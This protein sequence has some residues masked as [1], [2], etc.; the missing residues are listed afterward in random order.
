MPT[1]YLY[2]GDLAIHYE[3]AGETTLPGVP[4]PMDRGG[5]LLFVH[6]TG[7]NGKLWSRQLAH[8]AG[9]HSPVAVDL[10]GHGRSGGL[11]GPASIEAAAE[12][13]A[14]VLQALG[15][16]PAVVVGH[17]LGG[18][19]ALALALDHAPRVKAVVTIGTTSAPLAAAGEIAGMRDVVRG[20]RSQTF[21]TPLFAAKPDMNVMREVWGEIVK[22]DPRVRL[23]DL[24]A[25]GG[26]DLRSRLASIAVPT[27]VLHGEQDGYCARDCGEEIAAAIPGARFEVVAE[28]GHVAQLEQ[29]E[30]VNAIIEELLG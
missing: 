18:K 9:S 14:G 5:A 4:P 3:H 8:F 23:Q 29:P 25:Y 21:D 20:R 24:E 22:T 17:G 30:R 1:K 27:R 6:D 19:I 12:I 13:L 16:P 2:R 15:A 11:D 7:G 28:A 26:C 10:P